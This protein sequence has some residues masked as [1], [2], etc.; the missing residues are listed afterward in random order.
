MNQSISED[1]KLHACTPC[2]CA[3]FHYRA[4]VAVPAPAD[5]AAVRSV[6]LVATAG[7]TRLVATLAGVVQPDTSPPAFTALSVLPSCAGVDV[8]MSRLAVRVDAVLSEPST[9]RP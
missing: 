8:D 2:M 9:V 4:Y 7:C 3:G 6:V 1:C 5:R